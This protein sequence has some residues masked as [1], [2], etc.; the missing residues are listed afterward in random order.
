MTQEFDFVIVGG[1][2][3]GCLLASR[4]ANTESRPS[5]AL[6]EGGKDLDKPEYRLTAERF[7]TL[8][9]PGLDYGYLSTPQKHARNREVLQS[10]GKGLGGSSAVNFQAWSLGA[11]EEFDAWAEEAGDEAWGFESIIQRIKQ[12]ENLHLEGVTEEWDEYIKPGPESHGFSGPIDVSIGY[13]ERE[14]KSF[15]DAGEDLGHRRNLDANSGDLIGFSLNPV[16]S[17][18]SVRTTSASAFLEKDVPPNLHILTETRIVKI[19]FENKQAVGVLKEDGTEIRAKKEVIVS[20]GAI[21]TPRLLLLS[22][23]GPRSELEDLGIEVVK[24]LEGVGKSFTDHPMVVVCFQMKPGFTDRM[25]LADPEKYQ[26]AV[27]QFTETGT[28]PLLR[29]FSSIPHAFLKNDRAYK[30]P[31]FQQLPEETKEFLLKPGVPSYELVVSHP[32]RHVPNYV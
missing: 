5:V 26:E 14:T 10:R 19:L 24:D 29:H 3:A 22:G 2:T 4:L 8:L 20:A 23:V 28:G 9:Q 31:E 6:L 32:T 1:G 12:L 7:F 16:T 15:I 11:R 13:V 17:L 18:N 27:K 25:Q 21:D 30:T